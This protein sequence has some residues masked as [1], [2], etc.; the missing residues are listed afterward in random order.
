[1]QKCQMKIM[2]TSDNSLLQASYLV[3][4]RIAKSKKTF[5]IGEELVKPCILDVVREIL[6]PQAAV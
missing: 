2:T 4:L 3:A 6:G 1:M 5:P